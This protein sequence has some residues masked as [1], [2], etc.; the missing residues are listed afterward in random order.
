MCVFYSLVA[1]NECIS[2]H[3][4]R[5]HLQHKEATTNQLWMMG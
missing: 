3:V 5:Q 2:T 1:F 4:G